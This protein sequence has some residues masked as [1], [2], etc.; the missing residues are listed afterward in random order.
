[1][2]PSNEER[3]DEDQKVIYCKRYAKFSYLTLTRQIMNLYD[4]DLIDDVNKKSRH[5]EY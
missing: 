5:Y 3:K 1:M 2:K 4:I